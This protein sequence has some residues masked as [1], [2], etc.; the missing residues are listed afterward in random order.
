MLRPVNHYGYIRAKKLRD[1]ANI[2]QMTSR[3]SSVKKLTGSLYMNTVK[4]LTDT[5]NIAKRLTDATLER[6]TL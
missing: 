4:R 1:R 6:Q 3:L 2:L 5:R